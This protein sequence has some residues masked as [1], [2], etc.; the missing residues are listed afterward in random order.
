MNPAVQIPLGLMNVDA[1][2]GT[3]VMAISAGVDCRETSTP[4]IL[5]A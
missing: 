5:T 2:L 1:T 4:L 3:A